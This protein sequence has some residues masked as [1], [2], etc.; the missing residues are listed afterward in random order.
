MLRKGILM[1]LALSS[2]GAQSLHAVRAPQAADVAVSVAGLRVIG[3]GAG[4]NGSELRA[5][6]ESPGLTVSLLVSAAPGSRLVEVDDDGCSLD[7]LVAKDGTSLLEDVRWSPF[8]SLSDSGDAAMIE[9]SSRAV[10]RPGDANLRAKGGIKLTLAGKV[11][12]AKAAGFS[13]APG[14]EFDGPW[15]HFKVQVAEADPDS[16]SYRLVL[17]TTS[18]TADLIRNLDF[19]DA[20]GEPLNSTGRGSMT[21]GSR[22]QLELNFEGT[23][24]PAELEV[25]W[26]EDLQEILVPFDLPITLALGD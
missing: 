21:M 18:A 12:R 26:F 16:D 2:I 3:A 25:E 15:G 22:T 6:R 23:R 1:A 9:F 5:F 20:G 24:I 19:T 4:R 17:E 8:P 7:S 10:P 14:T 11:V 13:H